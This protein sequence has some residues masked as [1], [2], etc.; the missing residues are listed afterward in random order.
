MLKAKKQ[1]IAEA[2]ELCK[3]DVAIGDTVAHQ[4]H[5]LAHALNDIVNGIGFCSLPGGTKN[6]FPV[7]ELADPNKVR[8]MAILIMWDDAVPCRNN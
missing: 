5:R 1:L 6:Q 8:D 4:S 7:E 3:G 2:F